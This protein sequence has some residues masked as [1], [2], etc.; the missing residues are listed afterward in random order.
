MNYDFKTFYLKETKS[1]KSLPKGFT[2]DDVESLDDFLKTN[3]PL[4]EA[5][6]D[7]EISDVDIDALKQQR[8]NPPKNIEI[9]AKPE[10]MIHKSNIVDENGNLIDNEELKKKIMVRPKELI[11]QN[12]K[13]SKSGSNQMFFDLTLPSYQGLWVDE[14][15]GDFKI[16]KTCPA[17][18]ECKK[19]CYAAKSGYIQFP[20]SSILTSRTV[21]YL[22]ND[23]EGF[24]AQLISELKRAEISQ[25]KKGKK[26]V[27][28]WHDSGDFL[29]EKYLLLAYDVAKETPD[30][31][32][33]AYTK[34]VPLV[35]KLAEHKPENFVFNFSLGGIHD[36]LIDTT[37]EKHARVVPFSL[38]KD[39]PHT[40]GEDGYS[41]NF[42]PKEIKEL[43][44]RLADFYKIPEADIITY[45]E[46]IKLP[47]SKSKKYYVMVWKGN[48]D[49]A[50][51][52][53]D[54]LG[55][56]LFFH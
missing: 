42:A 16:V 35:R 12:K 32:H 13:L 29:S 23:P 26:V 2:M 47:E 27:L 11:G 25:A 46:M 21:N 36:E 30:I 56:L 6:G 20:R 1:T 14:S 55:T 50:A 7:P 52:R 28:R 31:L 34:Q 45:A 40:K 33:Y 48:G 18:G 41:V 44:K 38:F 4:E 22:M 9:A 53:R 49:D 39:V 37:K 5:E 54:V 8:L 10:K 15:T 51:T 24:K 19:F 43:K 17:A 3:K